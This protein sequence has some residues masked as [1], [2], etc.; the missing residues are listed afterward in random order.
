MLKVAEEA[1]GS[2]WLVDAEDCQRLNK[3]KTKKE[4]ITED[5]VRR[6][7]NRLADGKAKGVDGWSPAELRALLCTHIEGPTDILTKVEDEERWPEGLNPIIALIP[8]EGPGNEGQLRPIA[9]L[10]YIY[11]VWTAARESKVTQWAM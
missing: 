11:R 3:K 5:E 1:W 9:V 6:V 2:L 8:K 4:L 10:P 7:V